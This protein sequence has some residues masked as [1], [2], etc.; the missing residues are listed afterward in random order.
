MNTSKVI[1]IILVIISLT[2][3]YVGFNKIAANT[4]EINLL[5]I[6]IEASNQSAKQRGYSYVGLALVLFIAG[7]YTINRK[8]K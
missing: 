4:N 5:G 7:V 8:G 2:L 1:G 6:K 3:G